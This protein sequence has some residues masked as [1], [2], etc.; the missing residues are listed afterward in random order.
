MVAG[1]RAVVLLLVAPLIPGI[2]LVELLCFGG[3]SFVPDADDG[4]DDQSDDDDDAEQRH[5][6]GG[7]R[8]GCDHDCS[9]GV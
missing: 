7:S 4:E 8:V 1:A 3:F 6:H 5:V 2:R 9:F